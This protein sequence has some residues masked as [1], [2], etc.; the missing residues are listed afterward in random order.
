[1]LADAALAEAVRL[2]RPG[3]FEGDILAAMQG[4]VFRGGGDYPGN[5]F[6]IGSG[7]AALLV[8]TQSDRRHLTDDDQLTL[9]FAG[10]YKHYHA[11]LMRTLKVGRPNRQHAEMHRIGLDC[12]EAC[13]AA[14][15]PGRPV[16]EVF[17]AY[18]RTIERTPY[19]KGRLNACGYS[20]GATFQPNWMDWPM[21]YRGNPVLAEP[22][23]VFFL[24]MDVRDDEKGLAVVPG[25]TV[26]L[27]DSGCE[28]LSRD[29]L[30]YIHNG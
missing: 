21:F 6:I 19:A 1:E 16:G 26:L 27:T 11:C 15:R 25:E 18:L 9:E 17:E 30:A 10:V 24:H 22:G 8:R 5:T 29:S 14:L 7:G 20:L 3:A 12:L 13:E 28:R 2:A 4:A 23:M